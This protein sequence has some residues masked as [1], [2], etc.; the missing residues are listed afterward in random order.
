MFNI[1]PH[2]L[3]R[4]STCSHVEHE[5]KTKVSTP[6]TSHHMTFG[7]KCLNCGW[8]GKKTKKVNETI[9]DD[10]DVHLQSAHDAIRAQINNH[11]R[12]GKD[13]KSLKERLAKVAEL[14]KKKKA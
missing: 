12:Q 4:E 11:D 10:E 1:R 5:K 8:V 6:C 13:T 2:G 9:V 7:G 3:I 14:L